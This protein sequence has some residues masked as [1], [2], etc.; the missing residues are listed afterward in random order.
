MG[1][2]RGWEIS[3]PPSMGK[4][5]TSV[6][7]CACALEK[8]AHMHGHG[9]GVCTSNK[10]VECIRWKQ[11]RSMEGPR[12]EVENQDVC[13]ARLLGRDEVTKEEKYAGFECTLRLRKKTLQRRDTYSRGSH[14]ILR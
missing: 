2:D 4:I 11:A 14:E 13:E 12:A 1:A 8:V 10:A 7:R 3:K 5:D 6:M 9:N